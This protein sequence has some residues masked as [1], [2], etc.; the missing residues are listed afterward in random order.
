MNMKL[1][2]LNL[3]LT[4]LLMGCNAQKN[5]LDANSQE[6]NK[7]TSNSLQKDTEPIQIVGVLS[8]EESL[9]AH[10]QISKAHIEGNSL[11][12]KIG[13]SGG[14]S[15]HTFACVGSTRIS[16]SLPPI[17]WVKLIHTTEDSCREYIERDLVVDIS[18]FA[19]QQKNGSEIKLNID[20]YG[21]I[22]YSFP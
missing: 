15:S 22:L 18:S 11:V 12:L 17:R 6:D 16:K 2:F 13:Y 4:L 7:P 1:F 8:D 21:Q 9:S 5:S 14:C 3:F 19:Y 10:V 20:G